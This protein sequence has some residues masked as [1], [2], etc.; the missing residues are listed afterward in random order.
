[1]RFRRRH[2]QPSR[3][4]GKA[5][6]AINGDKQKFSWKWGKGIL[7]AVQADFGDPVNGTPSYV[8]CVYDTN[9]GAPSLKLS[10][11]INAGGT[12]GTKPCWKAVSDKGWAYKNKIGNP[13]GI[14]KLGFK[15]G[16]AGKSSLQ[17]GGAGSSLPLPTPISGSQFFA[18]DTAVIVQLHSSSP[19]NC[20]SSTF[21]A[22]GTKKNDGTMFKAVTP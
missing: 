11:A 18:A 17:V 22:S 15:G 8:L 4:A 12:C 2:C 13:N 16:L 5:S 9:A 10:A 7:Q 3:H 21:S 14:T 19:A 20:W 6:L 1:L